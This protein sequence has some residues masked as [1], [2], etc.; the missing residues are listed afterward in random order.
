MNEKTKKLLAKA[1][2]IRTKLLELVGD[3]VAEQRAALTGELVAAEK[4][5][6]TALAEPDPA[7]EPENRN[8]GEGA[9]FRALESRVS[10]ANYIGAAWEG[11]SIAGAEVEFNQALEMGMDRFPLRL[12][13]P[14]AEHRATT[15]TDTAVRPVRWLDR[16]FSDTAAMYAGITF[17]AVAPGVSSHPVTSAG[18]GASQY[19]RE[20]ATADAAWT[21]STVEMKPKRNSV[22]AVF[23]VEDASRLPGLE[24]ALQRDLRMALTEG[25]DRTVFLGDAT[26]NA[27]IVGLNTAAITEKTLTQAN[28]VKP[29]NTLTAFLELV[30]GVHA[31][32]LS[33]LGVVAS[34]GANTLW[35]STIANS[36]AENQTLAQFLMASG[37]SWKTRG[38]IEA[39]TAADDFA[40][41]IGRKRG[42]TGA[43]VVALWT[44][45]SL[46]RDPYSGAAK[47][48][49]ALTLHTLWDFALPRASNFARLKFVA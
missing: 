43:G 30:D 6:Q 14:R 39:N 12:L 7:N 45:G 4:A 24:E 46:L 40:A 10:L 42:I 1:S 48:E 19:A 15:D 35:G 37:M 23:T 11:R 8:G 20:G 34:V 33:E 28:K 32:S 17:D 26:S 2:E 41:F 22:R 18:A 47:G 16:L 5:I 9:E 49:V 13:A 38:N 29:A 36:A 44:S 21:I 27:A 31:G 25:V 3:D